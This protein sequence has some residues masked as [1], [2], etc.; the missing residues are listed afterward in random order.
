MLVDIAGDILVAVPCHVPPWLAIRQLKT[1]I[2]TC[3]MIDSLQA[4]RSQN[5]CQLSREAS[6]CSIGG[7]EGRGQKEGNGSAAILRS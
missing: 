2:W 6:I 5:Y 4:C 1:E 7:G 3:P